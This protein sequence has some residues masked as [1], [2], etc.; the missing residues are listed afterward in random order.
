MLL[1][2][3]SFWPTAI[4]GHALALRTYARGRSVR[5]RSEW[6]LR[7]P[8]MENQHFQSQMDQEQNQEQKLLQENDPGQRSGDCQKFGPEIK[9]RRGHP[10]GR[11]WQ[12]RE[13]PSPPQIRAKSTQIV[14]QC[15]ISRD[16]AHRINNVMLGV[17][18]FFLQRE[19]AAGRKPD[20]PPRKAWLRSNISSSKDDQPEKPPSLAHLAKM[21][22]QQ[23]TKV[24]VL[25]LEFILK[26]LE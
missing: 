7:S 20:E 17:S 5:Y 19:H 22:I 3:M 12:R 16:I 9:L 4:F 6:Q 25:L 10:N 2:P 1:C 18:A 24:H 11:T 13:D 21:P 8:T 26:A 14:H 15:P 23:K